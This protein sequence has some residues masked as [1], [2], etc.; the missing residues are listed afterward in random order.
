M[1]LQAAPLAFAV[2]AADCDLKSEA[3]A[4]PFTVD[5]ILSPALGN[6]SRTVSA[7]GI[8]LKL[9]THGAGH[10][11]TW[12]AAQAIAF[13]ASGAE[14]VDRH[15]KIMQARTGAAHLLLSPAREH[16]PRPY[17]TV[18]HGRFRTRFPSE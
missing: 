1:T 3:H 14:A 4:Q 15:D 16:A 9:D 8:D 7:R 11:D 18:L 10:A 17:P 5:V 12:L 13:T 6:C 2:E